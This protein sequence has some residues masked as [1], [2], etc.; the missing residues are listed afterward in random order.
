MFAVAIHVIKQE[1]VNPILHRTV[2]GH[3]ISLIRQVGLGLG[4]SAC[5]FSPAP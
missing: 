1:V 3:W 5:D 2:K 4:F